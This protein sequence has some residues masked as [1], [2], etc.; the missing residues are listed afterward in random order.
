M[1][2]FLRNQDPQEI[3]QEKQMWI[4]SWKNRFGETIKLTHQYDTDI[5]KYGEVLINEGK[6]IKVCLMN[7]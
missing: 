6:Q 7:L 3:I 4:L 5:Y 2:A 1:G